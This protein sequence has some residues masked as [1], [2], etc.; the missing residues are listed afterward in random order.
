MRRN[1]K[2]KLLELFQILAEKWKVYKIT[3]LSS[4]QVVK[5]ANHVWRESYN[6]NF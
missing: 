3:H 4:T 2:L 5:I 6:H 1:S